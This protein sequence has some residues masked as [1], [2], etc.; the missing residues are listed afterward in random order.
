M[1][2]TVPAFDE[3]ELK[4][5]GEVPPLWERP[6]T[7]IYDYPISARDALLSLYKDRRAYWQL[8]GIESRIFTPRVYPDNVARALVF[9]TRPFDNDTEGGG[10]DSFGVKWVYVP[11]AMGSMEDP[12]VPHMMDDVNDWRECVQFPDID[13]WDWE[14]SAAENNGTYLDDKL[15][16]VA[17][18]QTGFFERL[19]SFMGFEDASVAMIDEDQE[20]AV[21]ELM[22]ALA[23]YYNRLIDRFI[24]TFDNIDGFFI[25]D[26]WGSAKATFIDPERIEKLIVPAMRIVTD[27]LHERGLYAELHSCGC[28]YRQVPNMI[29]AGWDAWVPQSNV[30][31][32]DKI[33][34][35]FG[36]KIVIGVPA[37]F[38][39]EGTT[40]EE[41]RQAAREYAL[42]Y[43]NPDKPSLLNA[44]D[45]GS[46]LTEAFVEELYIC[47]RKL[48]A[49]E[50]LD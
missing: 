26:D 35:E 43:C 41:Q 3:K 9:E 38:D 22:L 34:N 7:K 32:V 4:V 50:P 25:H 20:D 31:D 17:W 21:A 40:E 33:Y 6:A 13:A 15:V 27:H 28:N 5:V 29:A 11:V 42:K 49:G 18:I 2:V 48:Y 14:G 19:I 30:N 36:D 10:L 46:C 37:K 47:S 24:D 8:I 23:E 44:L 39:V 1:T 12:A 45:Y 16:N